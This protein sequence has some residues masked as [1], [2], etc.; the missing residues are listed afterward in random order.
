MGF[1]AQPSTYI[2]EYAPSGRARCRR[3]HKVMPKGTLRVRTIAFVCPQR[4]TCFVRCVSCIDKPFAEAVLKVYE[5][6]TRIPCNVSDGDAVA[7]QTSL[8]RAAAEAVGGAA[9]CAEKRSHSSPAA[10][11][12]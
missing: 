12:S 2:I 7:A 6:A 8:R 5:D 3:C 4:V 1:K 11:H 10:C 9:G